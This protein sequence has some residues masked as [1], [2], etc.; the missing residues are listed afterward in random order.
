MF[1]YMLERLPKGMYEA[2]LHEEKQTQITQRLEEIQM[3]IRQK[4]DVV[5]KTGGKPIPV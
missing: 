5:I 3:I 2:R 4:T 1:E